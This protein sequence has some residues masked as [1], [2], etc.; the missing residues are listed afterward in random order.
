MNINKDGKKKILILANFI[1]YVLKGHI[2][3]EDFTKFVKFE[4]SA[5]E[6]AREETS[7]EIIK[8]L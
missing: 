8:A 4:F 3:N 7:F 6:L 5:D 1:N 2:I